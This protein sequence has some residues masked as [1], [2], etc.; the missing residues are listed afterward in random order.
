MLPSPKLVILVW[1]FPELVAAPVQSIEM[2]LI[3]G[4]ER[5]ERIMLETVD[6]ERDLDK[7]E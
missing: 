2:L 4:T 5:D 6:W 7:E 3:G 1:E